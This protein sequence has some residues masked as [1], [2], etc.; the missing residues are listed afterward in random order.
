MINISTMCDEK[1]L[2]KSGKNCLF[3]FL[4]ELTRGNKCCR[5]VACSKDFKMRES[6]ACFILL[7]LFNMV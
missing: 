3:G 6:M 4:L 1:A 2:K 7:K 5:N